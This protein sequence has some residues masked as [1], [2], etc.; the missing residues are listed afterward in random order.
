MSFSVGAVGLPESSYGRGAA[1][2]TPLRRA[3]TYGSKYG[4]RVCSALF[5]SL[6]LRRAGTRN[7]KSSAYE[8][9]G[10]GAAAIPRIGMF[11][12]N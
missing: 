1:W 6:I 9:A 10:N 5:A 11:I 12:E 3:G 4:S 8:R 7:L 2:F